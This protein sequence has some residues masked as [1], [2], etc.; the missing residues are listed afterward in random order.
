MNELSPSLG[1]GPGGKGARGQPLVSSQA[2]GPQRLE[3]NRSKA[4]LSPPSAG[5]YTGRPPMEAGALEAFLENL[6]AARQGLDA[7]GNSDNDCS[8]CHH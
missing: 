1:T 4:T 7:P 2:K 3:G 8:Q 6:G 5:L